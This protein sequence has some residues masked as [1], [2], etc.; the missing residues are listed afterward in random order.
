LAVDASGTP[1]IAFMSEDMPGF[2]KYAVLG[3]SEWQ[4]STVDTG[5][6]YGPL[7]IKVGDDG[8]PQIV[9]WDGSQWNVETVATTGSQPLGQQ[10]SLALDPQGVLHLTFA[11]ARRKA[12]P[13]VIGNVMY[14][15]G[16]PIG[17]ASVTGDPAT[18]TASLGK[19]EP[20]PN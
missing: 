7:D 8:V 14:G 9:S 5:Y 16:T 1:H 19:V 4:I 2:V 18:Q 12:G 10:V 6:F 15:R 11:D 3:S 20:D 13:G 17:A